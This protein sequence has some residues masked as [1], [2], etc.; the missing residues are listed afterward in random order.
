MNCIARL[1]RLVGLGTVFLET[2]FN[3]FV[4]DCIERLMLVLRYT[5]FSSSATSVLQH[6][7]MYL[8]AWP[9]LLSRLSCDTI[10]C[11]A[12]HVLLSARISSLANLTIQS[13][14]LQDISLCAGI[15]AFERS[16][17]TPSRVAVYFL[18]PYRFLSCDTIY[19]IA[20]VS[21]SCCTSPF[22]QYSGRYCDTLSAPF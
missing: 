6:D 15:S 9:P 19:C 8:C 21:S 5:L 18:I 20:I 22:L 4:C 14:V 13:C 17:N 1:Y 12:I 2:A 7:L 16:C 10:F 3:F 11:I